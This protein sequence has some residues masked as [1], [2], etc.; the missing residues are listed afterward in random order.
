MAHIKCYISYTGIDSDYNSLTTFIAQ[1]KNEFIFH[2]RY[3]SASVYLDDI[4]KNQIKEDDV[5]IIFG[6]RFYFSSILGI[7]ELKLA[8]DLNKP[9]LLLKGL[10]D[11][12]S[13]IGFDYSEDSLK[14][15]HWMEVIKGNVEYSFPRE[16]ADYREWRQDIVDDIRVKIIEVFSKKD[17]D[18]NN[19]IDR[20]SKK[21][22]LYLSYDSEDS[23]Y[24]NQLKPLFENNFSIQSERTQSIDGSDIFIAYATEKYLYSEIAQHEFEHAID[25]KKPILFLL[26]PTVKYLELQVPAYYDQKLKLVQELIKKLK[27]FITYELHYDFMKS[28]DWNEIIESLNEKINGIITNNVLKIEDNKKHS[29]N[30]P[31][32]ITIKNYKKRYQRESDCLSYLLR[33]SITKS[34]EIANISKLKDG[35]EKF[36]VQF[37]T[38]PKKKDDNF[39]LKTSNRYDCSHTKISLQNPSLIAI[40]NQDEII[41]L[42]DSGLV[43]LDKNFN[44]ISKYPCKLIGYNDMAIDE[45]TV[46]YLV[47]C[48]GESSI[49]IIDYKNKIEKQFE[50]SKIEQLKGFKPRFIRVVNNQIFIISTCSLRIDQ[51]NKQLIEELFGES[52]IYIF[53]KNSFNLKH[54]LNL[55]EIGMYQPW[56]LMI[57]KNSNIYTTAY[58][59]DRKKRILCKFSIDG[60][61]LDDIDLEHTYLSNDIIFTN[62]NFIF[63][64]ES[65]ISV[66]SGR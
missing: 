10:D 35:E 57:D 20:Q 40:N 65:E 11:I 41:V 21:I 59:I 44:E 49:K 45:D 31:L 62:D 5:F 6:T 47:K 42:V 43:L 9:I 63:F 3:Y 13:N 26:T 30:V 14:T 19:Q 24:I 4:R 58:H 12:T 48:V 17:G 56:N 38:V 32:N 33:G 29:L 50:K 34:N 1:I 7:E 15:R 22:N 16:C 54:F 37:F 8:L 18:L 53:D 66:Y 55:K 23:I 51:D 46:I 36:F 25:A 27:S 28:F 61:L 52:R 60:T 2:L 64:K 39:E